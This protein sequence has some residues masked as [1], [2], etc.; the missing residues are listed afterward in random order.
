MAFYRQY[1]NIQDSAATPANTFFVDNTSVDNGNNIGWV[2]YNFEFEI[3]EASIVAA[4][5]VTTL[6]SNFR[7]G[8]AFVVAAGDM[9]S[10]AIRLRAVYGDITSFGS[11]DA[12]PEGTFSVAGNIS[13][14]GNVSAAANFTAS[15]KGSI[16]ANAEIVAPL[17][18]LGEEW[19]KVPKESDTWR[20]I[21]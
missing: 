6:V 13:A 14:L 5:N 8:E 1:L 16:T 18:K 11:V 10:D 20:R 2:F 7:P 21:G 4:G 17:Y 19:T 15:V 12:I 9:S 3:G